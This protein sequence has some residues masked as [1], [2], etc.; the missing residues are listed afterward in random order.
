MRSLIV[1]AITVALLNSL[2]AC[3]SVPVAAQSKNGAVPH[4]CIITEMASNC[5]V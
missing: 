5:P 4:D 1:S 3:T 2:S